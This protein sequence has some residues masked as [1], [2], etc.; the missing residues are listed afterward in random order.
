M[1]LQAAVNHFILICPFYHSIKSTCKA[2]TTG[3]YTG[4]WRLAKK[5][6]CIQPRQTN[7][8]K[9]EKRKRKVQFSIYIHRNEAL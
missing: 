3:M 4:T 5:A 1:L 6:S 7:N 2:A 8:V 9:G